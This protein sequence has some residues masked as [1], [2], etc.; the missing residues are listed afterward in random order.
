MRNTT[1]LQINRSQF[2][3]YRITRLDSDNCTQ[4]KL[5]FVVETVTVLLHRKL[6]NLEF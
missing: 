4:Q 3:K 2:G 5:E 6:K 1:Q